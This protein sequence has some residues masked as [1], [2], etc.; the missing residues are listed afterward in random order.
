MT[1]DTLMEKTGCARFPE[2]WRALY[3]L[4]MAQYEKEGCRYAT[5]AYYD[6][7][8]KKYQMFNETDLDTLKRGAVAVAQNEDLCRLVAL[9]SYAMQDADKALSDME[10][11]ELPKAPA[12]EDPFPYEIMI[13]LAT[14]SRVDH[15]YNTLRSK[16]I[17]ADKIQTVL[18]YYSSGLHAHMGYHGREGY[19][20]FRWQQKIA[21]AHLLPIGRFNIEIS[22]TI[23][24][25]ARIFM[26]KEGKQVAL[27]HDLE[28]HQNGFPLGSKYF[29]NEEGTYVANVEETESSYIGYPYLDS[30]Y[31]ST[32]K[33]TLTKS[34]WEKKLSYGDKAIALHIPSKRK[35][36]PD[37]VDDSLK[38][39]AE[40]IKKYYPEEWTGVFRCHSWMCDPQ[41]IDLLPETS[42]ISHF[43]KRFKHLAVKSDGQ[44]ALRSVFSVDGAVD[45][46]T[47]PE[48][49][50]LLKVLKEHYRSGKAIYDTVGYFF[51]E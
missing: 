46:D 18:G 26:N 48:H 21:N 51:Y 16:G 35:V 27:A 9:I 12:G 14:F 33:I 36:T 20:N 2:R 30:G 17:P 23:N 44:G 34:E 19:E 13:G 7:L 47:L 3:P 45:Y 8:Q 31:V 37:I 32:E 43:C 41:L 5:P 25:K 49:T 22:A 28:L 6:D 39:A 1:I 10:G 40:F 29:E 11:F 15:T 4:A 42:N 24:A 50:G 38:E